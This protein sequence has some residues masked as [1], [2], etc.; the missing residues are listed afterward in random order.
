[1]KPE[2]GGTVWSRAVTGLVLLAAGVIFWLDRIDRLRARDYLEW[3]PLALVMIGVANLGDRRIGEAIVWMAVGGFFT[4]SRLGYE[5]PTI[6]VILAAWPLFISIAGVTLV[7][8]ALHPRPRNPAGVRGFHSAAFM[9]GHTNKV[10]S[11]TSGGEITAVMAGCEIEV[12]PGALSGHEMVIDV[13]A[14]WGGIEIRIPR[15]WRVV[16]KV[17]PI[18]GSFD[19][20]AERAGEDAPR[21]I[22]RGSAIMGGIEVRNA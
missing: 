17:A 16:G 4:L 11:P 19:N 10:L 14:M 21:V 15:G 13:L 2:S 1:M 6:W 3:W 18:V 20:K 22:I 8:H 5:L 9:G 12:A 7:V